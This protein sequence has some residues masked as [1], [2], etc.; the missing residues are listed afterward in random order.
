M[1]EE[2]IPEFYQYCLTGKIPNSVNTKIPDKT[3][4]ELPNRSYESRKV[5]K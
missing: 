2:G 1:K 3:K 4:P 5:R